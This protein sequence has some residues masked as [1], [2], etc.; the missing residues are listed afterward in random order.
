[1]P[2]GCRQKVRE[3]S[4]RDAIMQPCGDHDHR[5][6]SPEDEFSL[7]SKLPSMAASFLSA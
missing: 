7:F 2:R 1:M 3:K 4:S 6:D 5:I